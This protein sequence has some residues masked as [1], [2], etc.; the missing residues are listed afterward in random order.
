MFEQAVAA[1]RVRLTAALA[2]MR[3]ARDAAAFCEAERQV[4]TLAIKLSAA[5]A[6][7]V[8]QE[9]SDDKERVRAAIERVCARGVTRGITVRSVGRRKTLVRTVGG[10]E[11]EVVTPYA[12]G[13]P[14]G[15]GKKRQKR[16]SQGTGVYPVLDQLGISGRSTPALRLLVSRAMCEANSVASARELL[17]AGGVEIDHKRALRLTYMV[18]DDAL[19]ARAQA[20]VSLEQGEDGGPFAG[21]RVVVTVDGGRLQT[22]RRVAGRPKKGGRKRFVTEWREP[23]VL[24]LYVLGEDG[25][26]DRAIPSVIDGTLGNADAVYKLLLY[27]LRRMG[28]H[29][30]TEVMLVADGAKWI[31]KRGDELRQALGLAP[32]QFQEIVDYFHAVERLGDFSKTQDWKEEYRIGWLALQKRRL[33]A[34]KI[35]EIEAVFRQISKRDPEGI[36][37][38]LPYW[39]RNRE[40]LRYASYRERRM[41][42][43]SGAV[44]SAV[45]RVINLRLK[46]ASIFW[47]EEHAEGI[48]H[49]RAHAKSGRWNEL[50]ASVLRITGWR[51][52]SRL[53]RADQ[54]A[55]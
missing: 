49:L 14:R 37:T 12:V 40:R 53:R 16:G 51:P 43:G 47:T 8:L 19:R 31:W 18:T 17:A 1:F 3:E 54:E 44:E 15:S 21:R 5:M 39:E 11:V 26:R 35:E 20:M 48:L 45:R 7:S 24:T 10:E 9:L 32:E 33:K 27:H 23:K 4:R 50:E 52:T 34:G 29:Q 13:Q 36:A 2:Q 22:R 28:A 55:A 41:A 46:G 42:I 30:A 6:Q 25:R 38:Q